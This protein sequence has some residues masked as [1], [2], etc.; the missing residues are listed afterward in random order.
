MGF[1]D[2]PFSFL[3]ILLAPE[4]LPSN[5]GNNKCKLFIKDL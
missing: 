2:R 1:A 4:A 3:K 5:G